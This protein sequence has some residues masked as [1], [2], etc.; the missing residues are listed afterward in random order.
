MVL[1]IEEYVEGR[2]IPKSSRA[3]TSGPRYS[4]R[5][6]WSSV[7][8]AV[9]QARPPAVLPQLRQAA[10]GV[11][12]LTAGEFVDSLHVGLKAGM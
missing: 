5:A 6:D 8:P 3:L 12:G 7:R 9:R 1:M 11:I 4:G 2:P 10:L